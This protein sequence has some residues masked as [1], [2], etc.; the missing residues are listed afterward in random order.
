MVRFIAPYED[1]GEAV[2]ATSEEASPRVP[3]EDKMR[4]TILAAMRAAARAIST[5]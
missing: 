5:K 4:R 2:R 3:Y 1:A